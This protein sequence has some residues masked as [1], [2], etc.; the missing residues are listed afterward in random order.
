MEVVKEVPR[1]EQREQRPL[2]GGG[3]RVRGCAWQSLAAMHGE[4]VACRQSGQNQCYRYIR[5]DP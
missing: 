4:E 2:A 5:N 3:R 1:S